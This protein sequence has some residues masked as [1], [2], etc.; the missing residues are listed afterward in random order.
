MKKGYKMDD[1]R[2]PKSDYRGKSNSNRKRKPQDKG[3]S[4]DK[5]NF[6]P[7]TSAVGDNDPSWYIPNPMV[8]EQATRVSFDDFIGVPV[9]F[10]PTGVLGL[11]KSSLKPGAIMQIFMNPSPGYTGKTDP[12]VA[13]INQQGFRT[14]AR[15]SSINAKNTNYLPNDVT[16]MILAMGELISTISLAQRA[17]GLLWTYNVRNRTMPTMLV[18][19]SGV[20]AT[21]LRATAAPYLIRLNTLIV[22]ANKI[23][24]PSNIDYFK[25]CAQIFST[26]YRDS[27]SDMSELYV[28]VPRTT[29][30]LDET[31]LPEGTQ[32]T[33]HNLISSGASFE[34]LDP[35]DLLDIIEDKINSMLTSAT[36]NYVYSDIL[37]LATKDSSVSLLQF[38]PVDFNYTVT[39]VLDREFLLKI[40][41]ATI[42]GGPAATAAQYLS[43]NHTNNNDVLPDV[44]NMCLIYA[45]Q[46]TSNEPS[47]AMDKI[48][49]FS[50]DSPTMEERLVA[51]RLYNTGPMVRLNATPPAGTT[52]WNYYSTDK[53]VALGDHYIHS[54]NIFTDNWADPDVYISK[55]GILDNSVRITEL[56]R[57]SQHPYIYEFTMNSTTKAQS[58]E[59]LLGDLDFF[60]N[61]EFQT[62]NKINKLALF[63][64]FDVKDVTKDR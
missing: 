56:T 2:K 31:T 29:W 62:I 44:D 51:T 39:P 37:N 42:I 52:A 17:Y 63:A 60:T 36:Y 10:D 7:E 26:V 34:P 23:P 8:M 46:F 6:E 38:A 24:F 5:R 13:A 27:D 32:L 50:N 1:K 45:P 64:L 49:N 20:D 47:L 28:P 9:E 18:D 43:A 16:T 11:T 59:G 12:K 4:M 15:L 14:Y 25:K 40:N 48:I 53:G 35:D 19:I 21:K 58:F 33:T 30:D 41:N 55:S 54:V 57:F 3:K 61:L 22:E